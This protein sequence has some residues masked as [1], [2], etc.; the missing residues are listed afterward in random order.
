[1]RNTKISAKQ[2][3]KMLLFDHLQYNQPT[4]SQHVM[5]M[6]EDTGKQVSRHGLN[7]RFNITAVSFITKLFEAFLAANIDYGQIT[8]ELQSKYT[9]IRILDSTEFKLPDSL[10]K[11][12]PGYSDSNAAACAAIQFEYDIISRKINC[13]SLGS[14]SGSDKAFADGR[15]DNIRP[16]ELIIRDL[17]YYGLKSYGKI[18]DCEAL[19]ISRLKPN[20]T[21]WQKEG[22]EYKAISWAELA[23]QAEKSGGGYFDQE[24]YIGNEEKKA[25]RLM[26]WILPENAQ[27]ARLQRKQNRKGN[28]SSD[29]KAWSRLN[30]FITNIPFEDITVLQAYQLYRIRWQIELMFKIWKSILKI[31]LV[32]KMKPERVKC[33][34]YSMF[35]WILL[36]W[37]ITSG[38]EPVIWKHTK[39]LLSPYKCYGLL[40]NQACRL[41]EILFNT[42]NQ[43]KGWLEK[44]LKSFAV[45]GL[46]ENKKGRDKIKEMLGFEKKQN[47]N[48]IFKSSKK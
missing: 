7:K 27:Q 14:A 11:D 47:K 3:L 9:A 24:V 22:E 13:L 37:D 40:K 36:C 6:Q 12:F 25:V 26:A 29:D 42:R 30:V 17:G 32:R 4:L 16:S 43:L 8:T 33:Y 1:M 38:F 35:I 44:M 48:G 23:K 19:Y 21:V 34:L 2:F 39:E 5:E 45:L 46:K 18:E 15:M 41:K 10:A 20:I 28:I 31:H